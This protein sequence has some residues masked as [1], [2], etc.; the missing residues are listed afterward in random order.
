MTVQPHCLEVLFIYIQACSIS[1]LELT[2]G[3][4]KQNEIHKNIFLKFTSNKW[5]KN[6]N[7]SINKL[8]TTKYS[9]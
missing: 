9:N 2:Q 6:E 4:I 5:S 7:Q 8:Y 1:G 3:N